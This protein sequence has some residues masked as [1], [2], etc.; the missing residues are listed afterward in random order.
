MFY[1]FPL[2]IPA[3]TPI[4]AQV[5]RTCLVSPGRVDRVMVIFPTGCVALVHVRILRATHQL[6]PSNL[7]EAFASESEFLDFVEN[8][9]LNDP[10]FEFI[11]SGW[12]D[13][14]TYS[15]TIT[16]RFNIRSFEEGGHGGLVE[17]LRAQFGLS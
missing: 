5:T 3:N 2:T 15:H 17:H 16:V 14:D 10:P 6:W 11:L 7:D 1:N 8:Y 9:P 13:D 4:T 12:N